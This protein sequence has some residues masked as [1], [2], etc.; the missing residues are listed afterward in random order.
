MT[1]EERR[2]R[3]RAKYAADPEYYRAKALRYARANKKERA[4]YTAAYR[5]ANPEKVAASKKQR[6]QENPERNAA[7]ARAH[8]KRV[9]PVVMSQRERRSRLKTKYG[10]TPS[11]FGVML[12]KQ[13]GRCMICAGILKSGRG[14]HIDHDHDTGK[15]RGLLC[16]ACNLILG[17]AKDNPAILKAAAMYLTINA[18]GVFTLSGADSN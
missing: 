16:N 3:D 10:L 12:G 14:T 9:G 17:H 15:V 18:S 2:A 6:H 8:R 13:E 5:A 7:Y 1:P 4:A 11:A